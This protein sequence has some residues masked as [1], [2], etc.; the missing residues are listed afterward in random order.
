VAA[1]ATASQD[2][3]TLSARMSCVVVAGPP[4]RR[5]LRPS[6]RGR[7]AAGRLGR[8]GIPTPRRARSD[9]ALVLCLGLR[10]SDG[11]GRS[12]VALDGAAGQHGPAQ[13]WWMR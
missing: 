13:P 10:A 11:M 9:A 4:H 7:P 3:V 1:R 2:L 8:R 6:R 5:T 12:S